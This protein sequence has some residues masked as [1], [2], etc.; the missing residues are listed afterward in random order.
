MDNVVCDNVLF[1][2]A[3]RMSDFDQP[4]NFCHNIAGTFYEN[5]GREYDNTLALAESGR[6]YIDCFWIHNRPYLKK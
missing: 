5:A 3:V 6:Q 2:L 1:D 4:T